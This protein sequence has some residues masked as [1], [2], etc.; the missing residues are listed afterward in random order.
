MTAPLLV[1]VALVVACLVVI[2]ELLIRTR[3]FDRRPRVGL[4][5]WSSLCFVGWSS[6]LVLC[7]QVALGDPRDGLVTSAAAFARHLADGHPL[8]GLGLAEVVGLSLAFDVAA[9][10]GGAVALTT[11]R[12][13]R[14][15]VRQRALL[16]LVADVDRDHEEVCLL[17]HPF[18]VAYYLP[19]AGGRVVLSTG[20]IDLLSPTEV[21]AVVAHELGHRRGLH[22]AVLI[23]LQV[24]SSFVAFLPLARR[25]PVAMRSLLEMSADDYSRSRG[26]ADGLRTALGKA[27]LFQPPPLGA[28]GAFDTVV[29]RRILRLARPQ[30]PALDAAV[31]VTILSASASIVA[32]LMTAR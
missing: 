23:P 1:C 25:A 13:R 3:A 5:V 6:V 17:R 32:F 7:L 22:G 19:G 9:L 24:L 2:P 15:R 11:V 26:L 21:H 8:R 14:L 16:D 30:T 29:E 4:V 18:P 27:T 28:L 12:A 10:F 31:V 20:A